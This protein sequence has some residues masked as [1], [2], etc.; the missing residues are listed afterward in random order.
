MNKRSLQSRRATFDVV[1]QKKMGLFFIQ[2]D[3][4]NIQISLLKKLF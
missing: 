4:A 1:S 3:Y 2:L